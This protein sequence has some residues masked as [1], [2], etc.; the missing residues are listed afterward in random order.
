MLFKIKQSFKIK[1]PLVLGVFVCVGLFFAVTAAAQTSGNDAPVQKII[2]AQDR[3]L[4]KKDLSGVVRGFIWGVPSVVV[5]E[6]ER[7]QFMDKFDGG[8]MYLGQF[9]M[10]DAVDFRSTISYEFYR[11][12]LWRVHVINER[13]YPDPQDLIILLG[14]L[15]SELEK[16]FGAPVQEDFRWRNEKNKNWPEYW[17]WSVYEGDLFITIKW[18]TSD[19]VITLK[20]GAQEELTPR[21]DV[22]YESRMIGD[23]M[24]KQT[25]QRALG[26]PFNP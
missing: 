3:A 21:L 4:L 8:L 14:E 19:T 1:W 20:L 13:H 6:T 24:K 16:K 11:D 17:G 23:E 2:T 18:V 15:Q 25:T 26:V 12:K 10:G 7:A 5:L 22:V 9:R